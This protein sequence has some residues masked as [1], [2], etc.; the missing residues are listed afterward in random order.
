MS[1][2]PINFTEVAATANRI[3]MRSTN[4]SL[5]VV[6]GS[7]VAQRQDALDM[8][9]QLFNRLLCGGMEASTLPGF[10]LLQPDLERQI[11]C[12]DAGSLGVKSPPVVATAIPPT[13]VVA[14]SP[15]PT[16]GELP[17]VNNGMVLSNPSVP[18]KAA[19]VSTISAAEMLQKELEAAK[20]KAS[21]TSAPDTETKTDVSP[22][23]QTTSK[24]TKKNT[25]ASSAK[26][27][28]ANANGQ[29]QEVA[30]SG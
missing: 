9:V 4:R 25:L 3:P 8:G 28:K 20:A 23:S 22:K 15:S 13:V 12:R 21:P 1:P 24:P 17:S 5:N 10:K 29:V 16:V 7:R 27:V 18:A 19:N 6:K 14:D 11:S 30:E 26:K 2:S